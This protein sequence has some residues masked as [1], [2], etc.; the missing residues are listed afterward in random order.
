MKYFRQGGSASFTPN[1]EH[2]GNLMAMGMPEQKCIKALKETD[3]NIERAV[4]WI[5]SHPDDDGSDLGATASGSSSST[6]AN[7]S[8]AERRNLADGSPIYELTGFISHI[9]TSVHCGH[10]VV[11]IKKEDGEWYIFNDNKVAKSEKPPKH[12]GYMYMYKR[13]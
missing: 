12:L 10:Y 2:L 7:A 3:N 4:D 13:K 11:H 8:S 9:G 1:P 5:F 6:S